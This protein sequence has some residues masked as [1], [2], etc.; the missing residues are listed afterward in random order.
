MSGW[1]GRGGGASTDYW[2]YEKLERGG[3]TIGRIATRRGI[4]GLAPPYWRYKIGLLE[5]GS[6]WA[7]QGDRWGRFAGDAEIENERYGRTY[8][9]PTE[10]NNWTTPASAVG[11]V[12]TSFTKCAESCELGLTPNCICPRH[13][14]VA[15]NVG[16]DVIES[17]SDPKIYLPGRS[18]RYAFWSY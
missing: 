1:V 15:K 9:P 8:A 6:R 5:M 4:C 17:Q 18:A 11:R 10:V 13:P 12:R 2:G 3:Y 14:T 7:F 16:I